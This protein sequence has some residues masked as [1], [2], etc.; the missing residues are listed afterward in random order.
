LSPEEIDALVK[1]HDIAKGRERRWRIVT[2][3]FLILCILIAAGIGAVA[4]L[5]FVGPIDDDE[6]TTVSTV[7]VTTS[8]TL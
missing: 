2:A 5:D 8:L 4:L 3:V 7:A 1:E 6:K